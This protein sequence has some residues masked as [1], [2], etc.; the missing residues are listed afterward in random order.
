MEFHIYFKSWQN[1]G[2]QHVN[3][4]SENRKQCIW[5]W[6]LSIEGTMSQMEFYILR[7]YQAIGAYTK[8][9]TKMMIW[10]K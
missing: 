10:R 3:G 4:M 2:M 9:S 6:S 8:K 5:H 7:E 1:T